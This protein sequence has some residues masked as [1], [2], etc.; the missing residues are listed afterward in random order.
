MINSYV[1]HLL[2]PVDASV[3]YRNGISGNSSSSTLSRSGHTISKN[4]RS[5]KF[6]ALQNIAFA[7]M[8]LLLITNKNYQ[9]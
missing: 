5:R 3:K 7:V 8:L 4:Q 6:I 1:R 2:A 9:P